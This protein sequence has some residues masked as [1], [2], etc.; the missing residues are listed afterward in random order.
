MYMIEDKM[1]YKNHFISS[2]QISGLANIFQLT[3]NQFYVFLNIKYC[4]SKLHNHNSS[5]AILKMLP[6]SSF[7]ISIKFLTP[8]LHDNICFDC[9]PFNTSYL[10]TRIITILL[11]PNDTMLHVMFG[12]LV[13]IF[14]ISTKVYDK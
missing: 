2:Y 11:I 7:K 1:G 6:T 14:T 3:V 4:H 8:F 12:V 5:P 9:C 10:F 13:D